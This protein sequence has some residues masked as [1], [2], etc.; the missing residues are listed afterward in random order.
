MILIWMIIIS[1]LSLQTNATEFNDRSCG[2]M[3]E[4]ACEMFHQLNKFRIEKGR[5][6][7]TINLDCVRAAQEHAQDMY[8]R[9]YFSHNSPNETFKQRMKRHGLLGNYGENIA[10]APSLIRAKNAWLRSW[11]HRANILK[12]NYKS[13]GVGHV[14]GLWVQCFSG[15]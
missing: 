2:D 3:D 4:S 10:K 11:G 5:K 9:G 1:L 12:S 8:D 6:A 13:T 7:L 15:K 14:H